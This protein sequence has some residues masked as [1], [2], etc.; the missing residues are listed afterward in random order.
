M[1][2]WDMRYSPAFALTFY[3]SRFSRLAV[4]FSQHNINTRNARNHIGDIAPAHHVRQRLQVYERR[5]S[6]VDAHRTG[7][8]VTDDIYAVLALRRFD[9][10]IGLAGRRL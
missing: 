4:N 6:E 1:C 7:R 10:L 3:V 2:N 9:A 8:A 5:A